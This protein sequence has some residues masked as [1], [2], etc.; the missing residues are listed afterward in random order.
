MPG[1]QSYNNI[2][3]PHLFL[4][5]VNGEKVC[6]SLTMYG[7]NEKPPKGVYGKVK[8]NGSYGTVLV[9][10]SWFYW[11]SKPTTQSFDLLSIHKLHESITTVYLEEELGFYYRAVNHIIWKEIKIVAL[12]V[13]KKEN[14]YE[15]NRF[16]Q[17]CFANFA[18]EKL[19]WALLD[20]ILASS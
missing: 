20:E 12:E 19:T 1:R 3:C 10:Q 5:D 6:N 4:D 15:L 9:T 13:L 14:Y 16:V 11:R 8:S 7:N 18:G 17:N 2:R